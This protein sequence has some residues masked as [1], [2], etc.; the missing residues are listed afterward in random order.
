MKWW[1]RNISPLLKG[2]VLLHIIPYKHSLF[3]V[4]L[5]HFHILVFKVILF[6]EQIGRWIWIFFVLLC[7]VTDTH[8]KIFTSL[9]VGMCNM[10]VQPY[11]FKHS[12]HKLFTY[13]VVVSHGAKQYGCTRYLIW[14]LGNSVRSS[15]HQ[16]AWQ[17]VYNAGLGQKSQ[18]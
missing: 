1:F 9:I 12:R 3:I 17:W 8:A 10:K 18:L 5:F 4:S 13:H 7:L 14:N 2:L 15:F 16:W 11:L 6:G